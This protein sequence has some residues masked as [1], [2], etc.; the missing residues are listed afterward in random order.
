[1]RGEKCSLCGHNFKH[2]YEYKNSGVKDQLVCQSCS[3]KI[4]KHYISGAEANA[5]VRAKLARDAVKFL[6]I[7]EREEGGSE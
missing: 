7:L 1:M 4:A 6:E 2:N 5:S 3:F